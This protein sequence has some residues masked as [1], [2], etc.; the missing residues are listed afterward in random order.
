MAL[1]P[2]T[3]MRRTFFPM[4]KRFPSFLSSVRD[5]AAAWRE[6][7]VAHDLSYI[8]WSLSNRDESAALI[9]ADCQKTS[10]WTEDDLSET[11]RWLRDVLRADRER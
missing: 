8:A 7:I 5:S 6:L 2:I 3:V 9:R 10:D 4:G 11:G 1:G